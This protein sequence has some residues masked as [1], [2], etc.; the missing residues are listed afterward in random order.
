MAAVGEVKPMPIFAVFADTQDEPES[1][2]R[3][4]DWLETKLPFPV[5]RVTKGKL[6]D[7]AVKVREATKGKFEGQDYVR[8]L[9]PVY[10]LSNDGGIGKLRI[11]TCT[12]D[13]KIV[14][15]TRF[16]RTN[17]EGAITCWIGISFDEMQRMKE[18]QDKRITNRFPLVEMRMTR[19]DC[20]E[21]MKR[22]G[23]P[24]PPQS[25]CKFCPFKSDAKWRKL[26]RDEPEEF[27]QAVEFEKRLQ[28]A[29]AK[30]TN[31]DSVP[32]LHKSCKP[33]DQIDFRNDIERGQLVFPEFV[34]ECDGMCGV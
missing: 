13:F 21:W 24:E 34:D 11:R 17:C 18:N 7:E 10:T 26:Q 29:N 19:R 1:V 20:I 28:E 27:A 12:Q 5:H 23:F 9:L 31:L 22:N 14:P 2:Y 15:L 3:W 30:A 4:L 6:S 16:I 25:A 32:Y 8:S 33:L